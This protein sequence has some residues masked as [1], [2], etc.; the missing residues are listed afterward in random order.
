MITVL[1]VLK[2]KMIMRSML[3]IGPLVMNLFIGFVKIFCKV[4]KVFYVI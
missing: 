4:E 2:E 3:L 1:F